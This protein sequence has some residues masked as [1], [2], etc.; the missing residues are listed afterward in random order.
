M[1][2]S[3]SEALL[4]IVGYQVALNDDEC[5]I[6]VHLPTPYSAKSMPRITR[7]KCKLAT[8]R[9]TTTVSERSDIASNAN[10]ASDKS[11]Y[12]LPCPP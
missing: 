6:K 12:R 2:A 7:L 3:L 5:S 4:S 11:I 1:V 8:S 9:H 10:D